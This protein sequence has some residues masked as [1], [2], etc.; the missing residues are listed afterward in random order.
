MKKGVQAITVVVLF[1]SKMYLCDQSVAQ[2]STVIHRH[3]KI[4]IHY[5]NRIYFAFN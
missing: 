5:L 2:K 1:A 3:D 4:D